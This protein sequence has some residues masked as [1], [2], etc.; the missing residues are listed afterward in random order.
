MKTAVGFLLGGILFMTIACKASPT[1]QSTPTAPAAKMESPSASAAPAAAAPVAATPAPA[2]AR[3]EEAAAAEGRVASY[4]PEKQVITSGDQTT[5]EGTVWLAY[6]AAIKGTSEAFDDFFG[7]FASF[8]AR[9]KGFVQSAQWPRL[10]QHVRKYVPAPD[11]PS[12]TL[13]RRVKESGPNS[14]KLFIQSND[15]QKS[16][17][18]ITLVNEGGSWKIDVF[19]P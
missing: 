18:P 3:P 17:P 2:T 12:Y 5:P 1:V 14:I 6:K 19:T 7:L 9:N 13:C 15:P 10:L 4:C 8:H 11:K 16:D